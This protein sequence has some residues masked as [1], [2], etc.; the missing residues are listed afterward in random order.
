[1]IPGWCQHVEYMTRDHVLY[2]EE[3]MTSLV[4]QAGFRDPE[5]RVRSLEGQV[6]KPTAYIGG[7]IIQGFDKRRYVIRRNLRWWCMSVKGGRGNK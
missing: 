6:I 4:G 7:A 1:M 3:R 2:H 5:K